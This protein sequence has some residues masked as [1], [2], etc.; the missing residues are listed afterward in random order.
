MEKSNGA[1]L[2]CS[3]ISQGNISA[4]SDTQLVLVFS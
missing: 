2:K 3:A 1:G 4:R